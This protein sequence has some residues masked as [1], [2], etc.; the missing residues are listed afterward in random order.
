VPETMKDGVGFLLK[1]TLMMN[2]KA[3]LILWATLAL[4]F[5]SATICNGAY[6][7]FHKAGNIRSGPG[8]GYRIIGKVSDETVAQIPESFHDYDA[9]WIPIDSKTRYDGKTNKEKI[10]YTK[11]V[12][13]SLGAVVRGTAQDV[14]KYFAIRD[15]GWPREVQELI[16]RGKVEIGMTT[17]MVYYAWG[18]PDAVNQTTT[19]GGGREEWV[20][21]RSNS[22]TRHL[23]FDDDVLIEMRE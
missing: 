18:K 10:I 12:H 20:Y 11:W 14:D 1:R 15:S 19:S 13:R 8:T 6:F 22:E 23:Y 9:S 4:I 5:C 2:E 7:V 16:L 3:R 17:H 21:T